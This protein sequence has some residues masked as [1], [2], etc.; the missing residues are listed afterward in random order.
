LQF[1]I[2]SVLFARSCDFDEPV[3]AL[4][5]RLAV[6]LPCVCAGDRH[7]ADG[8]VRKLGIPTVLDQFI[9]QAVMLGQI[10]KRIEDKRLLNRFRW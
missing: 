4:C 3:H 1:A 8:G 9:Q 7:D 2:V 6:N 10:A 5:V